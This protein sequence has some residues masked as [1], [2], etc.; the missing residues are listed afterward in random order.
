MTLHTKF[1]KGKRI[2]VKLHDGSS[3]ID[4]YVE[5]GRAHVTLA[6]HGDIEIYKIKSMTIAKQGMKTAI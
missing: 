4:K 5:R 3:F 2:F 6:M 1:Y